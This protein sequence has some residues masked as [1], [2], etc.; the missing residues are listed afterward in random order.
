MK[1]GTVLL[2]KSVKHKR[3]KMC[4]NPH[5]IIVSTVTQKKLKWSVYF[6][7]RVKTL[8]EHCMK[9]V[10]IRSIFWSVFSCTQTEYRYTRHIQSEYIPYSVRIQENTDQK[11]SVFGHFSRSGTLFNRYTRRVGQFY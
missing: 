4:G 9:R 8:Q 1:I 3:E 5:S 7:I 11:N 2:R 10:Q 6:E